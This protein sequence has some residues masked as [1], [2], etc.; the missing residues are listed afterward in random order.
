[1]EE[2]NGGMTE[3]AAPSLEEEVTTRKLKFETN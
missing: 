3:L 2:W 1:M